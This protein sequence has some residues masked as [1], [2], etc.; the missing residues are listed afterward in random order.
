M[1]N[2]SKCELKL[3][4][5]ILV[6]QNELGLLCNSFALENSEGDINVKLH[7]LFFFDNEPLDNNT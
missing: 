4:T 7:C 3:N 6:M 2:N 1:I 5:C